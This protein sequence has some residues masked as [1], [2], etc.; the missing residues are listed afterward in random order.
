MKAW[1]REWHLSAGGISFRKIKV[2]KGKRACSVGHHRFK[3]RSRIE[4]GEF[5]VQKT[6]VKNQS[7]F[8]EVVGKKFKK[9]P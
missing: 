8:L 5:R 3:W 9:I 1:E 6:C 2:G 7:V 4:Y